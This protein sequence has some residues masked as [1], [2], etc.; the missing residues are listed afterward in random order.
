LNRLISTGKL[1]NEGIEVVEKVKK[2]ADDKR[3]VPHS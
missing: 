3:L 2:L 1:E